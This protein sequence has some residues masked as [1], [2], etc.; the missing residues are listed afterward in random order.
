[1]KAF[2]PDLTSVVI[3]FD[4]FGYSES[5]AGP[6]GYGGKLVAPISSEMG[7]ARLLGRLCYSGEREL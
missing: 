3:D 1:M 4:A 7:A 2:H 6:W 5:R